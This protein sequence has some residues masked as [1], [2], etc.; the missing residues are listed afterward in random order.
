V[1]F[2]SLFLIPILVALGCGSSDDNA[3]PGGAPGAGGE[4]GTAGS[5][6]QGGAAGEAGGAGAAGA[7]GAGGVASIEWTPCSSYDC[8]TLVVPADHAAPGGTTFSIKLKRAKAKVP[9]DRIGVILTNPGG[10]GAE[11]LGF[12]TGFAGALTAWTPEIRNR[13][14]IITFDPRGIG[15]SEPKIVCTGGEVAPLRKT[16]WTVQSDADRTARQASIDAFQKSCLDK[17]PLELLEHCGTLDVVEDLEMIRKGLGEEKLNWV[18][19]SYGTVIGAQYARVHP[20]RVRAIVLDSVADPGSSDPKAERVQ[21]ATGSEQIL[22]QHFELCFQDGAACPLYK[23]GDVDAA[24]IGARYDALLA[25]VRQTP[26]Q[27]AGEPP[28]TE[29]ELTIAT[30]SVLY[31]PPPSAKW[32]DAVAAAMAGDGTKVAAMARSYW[33]QGNGLI[34]AHL[35]ILAQDMAPA[36]KSATPADWDSWVTEARATA[37]RMAPQYLGFRMPMSAWPTKT[38]HPVPQIGALSTTP[39]MLVV[40]SR[41]DPITPWEDSAA[42]VTN[43][44]NGSHLVTYEGWGHAPT[45]SYSKCTSLLAGAFLIDPAQP[46]ASDACQPD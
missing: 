23:A 11:A 15:G 33:G 28:V 30:F 3:N 5:S 24:A 34:D 14:D 19:W 12:L 37:P 17:T 44:A 18:G 45:W 46:P 7:A 22:T 13:F 16:P 43:M 27:V 6:G 25:T 42:L 10:P 29:D 35:A 1:R 20:D 38:D 4:G 9:A 21:G 31:S 36:W 8:A 39:P 41:H 2:Q 32:R 40:A 26:L